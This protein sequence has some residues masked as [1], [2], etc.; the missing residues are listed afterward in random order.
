MDV[1]KIMMTGKTI[2]TQSGEIEPADW[3]AYALA[4]EAK[5]D[6]IVNAPDIETIPHAKLVLRNGW[7]KG[8]D[9]PCCKQ[10]VRLWKRKI[11]SGMCKGLLLIL[12]IQG[13]SNEFIH[14][15]SEF[16]KHGVNHGDTEFSKLFNWGLIEEKTKDL[17]DDKKSSG[18]WRITEKGRQFALNKIKVRKYIYV[19]NTALYKRED[20]TETS[21]VEAIADAFSYEELLNATS[22]SR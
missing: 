5:L 12:R 18:Y 21:I 9:C 3:K 11:N 6:E 16:T 4:L 1:R 7:E 15:P 2:I 20:K 17:V 22:I 8:V 10:K 13:S 14:V 19:Y